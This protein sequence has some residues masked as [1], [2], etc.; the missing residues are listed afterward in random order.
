MTAAAVCPGSIRLS[1][2]GR[3]I[4]QFSLLY[5]RYLARRSVISNRKLSSLAGKKKNII[6]IMKS[7]IVFVTFLA[8][9]SATAVEKVGSSAKVRSA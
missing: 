5:S 4:R 1:V 7:L 9:T 6:N 3:D 2:F 8:L